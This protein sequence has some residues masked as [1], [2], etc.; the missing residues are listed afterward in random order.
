MSLLWGLWHTDG[1]QVSHSS[2]KAANPHTKTR[3]PLTMCIKIKSLKIC[4]SCFVV[5]FVPFN[6]NFWFLK[7]TFFLHKELYDV[8]SGNQQVTGKYTYLPSDIIACFPQKPSF[9]M[10]SVMVQKVKKMISSIQ[11]LSKIGIKSNKGPNFFIIP[12]FKK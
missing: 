5:G 7:S 6:C 10:I 4:K 3:H 8:V 2:N 12:C 11:F 1:P 9:I